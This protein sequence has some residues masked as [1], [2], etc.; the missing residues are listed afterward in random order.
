MYLCGVKRLR[1]M[2]ISYL[3]YTLLNKPFFVDLRRIEAQ[4]VLIDKFLEHDTVGMDGSTL[5][6]RTP[7]PRVLAGSDQG[8]PYTEASESQTATGNF[9]KAP[10]GSVAVV[11]LRG[12]MLKEGTM[13]SYGTEELA[14]VIREAADAK[15]IIGTR[16]DIDSG[17]GAVD[18]IAPMLQAIAYSQAKGKPVVA[19]CDLC[20]SAAYY[21][22]CQ[23][24]R[25]V[26]DNSLSAEFGSIG[27]MMQ[28]PDYAKYYEQKGIKIHTIYSN[29][30][31]WKNAP[32]E[33]ARRGDYASIKAEQ[34]DPLARQFQE[35]VKAHRQQLDQ[36]VDGILNGRMF[37][38]ADALKYGLIDQ[39]GTADDATQL[40][41]R[42]AA[43]MQLERYAS[44]L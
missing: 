25:I 27:V 9:G 36:S 5:S 32:F 7:V 22:A 21:V 37:Y 44:S 11:T 15:N 35:A 2:K 26:A 8:G 4:A 43:S 14:A 30:S 40:V 24:N 33:A 20:A 28:F 3:Y 18:A 19:S 1:D 17:G 41:R 6:E 42:L 29:L 38:A 39:V 13:C 23:C 12:D 31:D 10:E 34:L 16:L